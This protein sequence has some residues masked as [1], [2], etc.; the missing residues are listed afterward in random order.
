[1]NWREKPLTSLATVINF[2]GNTKTN[3]GL[4]I[5]VGVDKRKYV[6]GKKIFDQDFNL[7]QIKPCS[8]H[9]EWNY[10]IKPKNKK[11]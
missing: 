11:K 2:I 7:I 8:F 9:E 10:V 5:K 4:K 3:A 6:K 1:M